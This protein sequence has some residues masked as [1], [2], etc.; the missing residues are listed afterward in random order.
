MS[1]TASFSRLAAGTAAN[2]AS[3]LLQADEKTLPLLSD[4]AAPLWLRL[5]CLLCAA[6]ILGELFARPLLL[7]LAP[8]FALHPETREQSLFLLRICLPYIIPAGTAALAMALLHSLRRF[9]L[10]SLSQGFFSLTVIGFA[11]LAVV[12]PA[13]PALLL[14]LGVLC[15]GIAQ[16]AAQLVA[17][18]RLG[19]RPPRRL[20][21][22]GAGGTADGARELHGA[23]RRLPAGIAGAAVPQLAMLGAAAL[24]SL[25]PTGSV[26]ALY[27]A[28]RVLE[29]PLGLIG[30][31]L[32]MASLPVMAA[33]AASREKRDEDAGYA[34]RLC[35]CL[36]LPAAAGLAAVAEPLARLLFFRGA[37][38]AHALA[39]A[40]SALCAYAPALPAYA[41]SRILLALCNARGRTRLAAL[42]AAL[43]VPCALLAGLILLPL[44]VIGP[45][46]GFCLGMWA[47]FFALLFGLR[48][49]GIRPR[50][51]FASPFRHAA[52]AVLV[53]ISARLL[54]KLLPGS[55]ASLMLAVFLPAA[56]YALFLIALGDPDLPRPRRPGK[57]AG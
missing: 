37:F 12:Y 23:F 10:P 40:S 49:A 57:H 16:C 24:A 38:D 56:L 25:L 8:G 34:L 14:A 36:S 55:P 3:G 29:F 32:G 43:A 11:G 13:D 26:A 51:P 41:A 5:T 47:Q 18:Y 19:M 4:L 39:A 35:L 15:G 44:G 53:F 9:F 45:P 7:L 50:I 30:A 21:P 28:E 2:G 20:R 42:S 52:G 17:L 6:V 1:L 54:L 48:R 33:S 27:Y 31:A 46:L 22:G